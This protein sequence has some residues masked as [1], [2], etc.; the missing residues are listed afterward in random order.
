[1]TGAIPNGVVSCEKSTI[2]DELDIAGKSTS[3]VVFF[4][5]KGTPTRAGYWIL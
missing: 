4:V 1:V 3:D 5:L 2:V